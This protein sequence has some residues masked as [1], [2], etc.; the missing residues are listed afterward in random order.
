MASTTTKSL[1]DIND[2]LLDLF[3]AQMKLG[4]DF[5]EQVTGTKPP[6][7]GDVLT[8]LQKAAPKPVCHVPP[9]CWMPLP[10]GE[11]VSVVNACGKACIRLVITNCDRLARTVNVRAEGFQGI[12][13]T[14]PSVTLGP[15]DRATVEVCLTVPEETESGKK[16]ESMIWVDGCRDHFLRWTVSVGSA[17]FDSCHE[18]PVNDCQDYRHHWY[19][20]FYCARTC[21]PGRSTQNG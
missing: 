15:M 21:L 9:P 17:A 2:A 11:C 5:F 13:V 20:H 3:Q 16:F 6:A 4:Q 12:K 10:L 18:V 1:G 8:A 14:P 7:I 19:D